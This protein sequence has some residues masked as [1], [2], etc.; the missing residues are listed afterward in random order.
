MKCP[1]CEVEVSKEAVFCAN[2]GSE[3][4]FPEQEVVEGADLKS[5]DTIIQKAETVENSSNQIIDLK[6]IHEEVE[7][8]ETFTF[9]FNN[10]II[11]E[12]EVANPLALGLP[13][14]DI[15]PPEMIVRKR[16]SL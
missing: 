8:E 13:D 2:C 3:L 14:W 7:K 9:E 6:S 15:V 10:E 11:E 4:L 1:S 12:E 16:N 5:L